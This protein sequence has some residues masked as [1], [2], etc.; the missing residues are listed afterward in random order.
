M[1]LHRGFQAMLPDIMKILRRKNVRSAYVF[2]SACTDRFGSESDLDFLVEIDET[3]PR[4]YAETWWSIL[5]A[6]E[7]GTGRS[8]DLLTPRNLE[9]RHFRDEVMSTAERL[10]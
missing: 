3:D 5:F 10:F 8:V 1:A 7:D 4:Q 2:G 6:L 9:N